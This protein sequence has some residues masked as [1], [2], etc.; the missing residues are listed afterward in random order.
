MV[1]VMK[2][3]GEAE[4]TL[5]AEFPGVFIRNRYRHPKAEVFERYGAL[6]V[7]RLRSD[8]AGA[9]TLAF[10]AG[11]DVAAYRQ[12]HARYWYAR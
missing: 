10:G 12:R 3:R 2:A 7:R 8:E 9:V 1:V 6:G 5:Q 4:M 11:L